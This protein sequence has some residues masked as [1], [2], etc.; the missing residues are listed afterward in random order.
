MDGNSEGYSPYGFKKMSWSVVHE[1]RVATCIID[2][3]EMGDPESAYG[4]FTANRDP[5]VPAE[6]IRTGGQICRAR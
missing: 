3:S 4:M 2:V 6:Q 5:A 1:G